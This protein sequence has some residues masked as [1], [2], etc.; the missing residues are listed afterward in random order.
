MRILLKRQPQIAIASIAS[1]VESQNTKGSGKR[2]VFKFKKFIE[3]LALENVE[4][5]LCKNAVLASYKFSCINFNKW[6]IAFTFETDRLVIH[7][8]I[9]GSVLK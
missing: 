2:F 8:I 9:H 3:K 4:F 5:A 1:F 7:K 6:V